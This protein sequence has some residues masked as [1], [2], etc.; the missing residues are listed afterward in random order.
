MESLIENDQTYR[1][2]VTNFSLMCLKFRIENL[3]PW[4]EIMLEKIIKYDIISGS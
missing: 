3:L 4:K 1:V 2:E